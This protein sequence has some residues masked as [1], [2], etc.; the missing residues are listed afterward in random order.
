M[1][2]ETQPPKPPPLTRE[3]LLDPGRRAAVQRAY[4]HLV[5]LTEEELVASLGRTLAG[6]PPGEDVWLFA[7]GSLIWNPVILH[8]GR[9]VG[10]VQGWHRSFCLRADAGRGSP[11]RPGLFLGLKPGG[12]CRGILYRVAAAEARAELMLVWRRE[13]LTGAYVPRWVQAATLEG[14]VRAIAMTVNRRHDRYV[15]DL[16]EGETV[17]W[18]A[19]A[20]G[21]LGRCCDYLFDTVTHLREAGI[22]DPRLERL[23]AAVRA[24]P[25]ESSS[26]RAS[27]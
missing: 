7:Y 20:E 4:P 25:G 18:I 1:G 2:G 24:F 16:E 8:A 6:H 11:D 3:S 5:L 22:A 17:R 21:G 26:P 10:K 9:K 13:M 14:P 12:A 23:A 27:A 19:T 15:G